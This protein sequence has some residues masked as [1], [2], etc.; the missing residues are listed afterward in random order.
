M[1]SFMISLISL[2]LSFHPVN[3]PA[4][5]ASSRTWAS[6]FAA[7]KEGATGAPEG[8]LCFSAPLAGKLQIVATGTRAT[9]KDGNTV[10]VLRLMG[11]TEEEL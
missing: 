1:I 10:H 8:T 3:P 9:V 2:S 4:T 11:G 5:I 6:A 7:S